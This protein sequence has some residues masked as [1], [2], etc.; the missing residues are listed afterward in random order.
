MLREIIAWRCGGL[1]A[2][3]RPQQHRC[4]RLDAEGADESHVA[5]KHFICRKFSNADD[6][7]VLDNC[8]TRSLPAPW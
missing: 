7:M 4:I 5:P 1:R 6:A 2:I 8:G 3:G